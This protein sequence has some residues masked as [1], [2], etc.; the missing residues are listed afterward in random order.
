MQQ[1]W[2]RIKQG[3]E[4]LWKAT[5]FWSCLPLESHPIYELNPLF[6][7]Q[8][9]EATPR[10][11]TLSCFLSGLYTLLPSKREVLWLHTP[12]SG[13]AFLAQRNMSSLK[14]RLEQLFLSTAIILLCCQHWGKQAKRSSQGTVLD[15][16]TS[17]GHRHSIKK[18]PWPSKAV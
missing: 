10:W 3:P 12:C 13:K 17:H 11:Q 9:S 18:C 2:T 4:L 16:K 8:I 7:P 5:V 6:L 1:C 14:K 15:P